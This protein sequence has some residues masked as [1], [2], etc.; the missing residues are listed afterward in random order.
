[1]VRTDARCASGMPPVTKPELPPTPTEPTSKPAI[2][3]RKAKRQFALPKVTFRRLVQE[4]AS[5]YKSDLRFQPDGLDALQEA[6][7]ALILEKFESCA[8][9][10][11][12]CKMDTVRDEHWRFVQGAVPCSGKS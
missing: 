12:L 2:A 6:A 11:E 7:E 9:L 10:A 5:N 1:V 8:R 4:I 3:K